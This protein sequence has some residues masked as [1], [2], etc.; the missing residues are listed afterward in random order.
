MSSTSWRT[1]ASPRPVPP[2]RRVVDESACE[3]GSNIRIW[4]SGAMP[5]PVS[6]TSK[7]TTAVVASSRD[8][9]RR[10]H[11][12]ALGGELHR[13]R[14]QVDEHL[15][16]PRRVAAQRGGEADVPVHEQLEVARLRGL[17][18]QAD[19]VLEQQAEVEVDGLELELA[20]LDLREVEDV[21]DDPEQPV[22]RSLHPTR[23]A[24]LLGV[25]RRIEQQLGQAD[26]RVHR[27]ADLVAHRREE[28]RLHPRRLERGITRGR[29]LGVDAV[30]FGDIARV[31]DEATDGRVF[32]EVE[33]R[34]FHGH[35]G[36]VTVTQTELERRGLTRT[37]VDRG[38]RLDD[39]RAC[40]SG[41]AGR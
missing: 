16:Q 10:E 22:G 35:P 9:R 4:S 13:V 32:D 36:S 17:G 29:E 28:L 12:L 8:E 26:H 3:N 7:R 40:R 31:H 33:H 23:V 38:E 6:D 18:E 14:H 11:D 19:D 20:R 24:T 21:V 25:Q 1:I 27:R 41:A 15:P 30:A 37:L 2:N 34:A 39:A 5:M